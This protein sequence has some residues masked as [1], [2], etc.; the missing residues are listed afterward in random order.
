[1]WA[2]A[3]H[4]AAGPGQS[5]RGVGVSGPGTQCPR[6][7]QAATAC[8]G[9]ELRLPDLA[10]SASCE[11][12]EPLPAPEEAAG[13]T[14]QAEQ[15]GGGQAHAQQP[16][17]RLPALASEPRSP[18]GGTTRRSFPIVLQVTSVLYPFQKTPSS[19]SGHHG[20]WTPP[21][22]QTRLGT[23]GVS[24]APLAAS[25]AHG[26]AGGCVGWTE[27]HKEGQVD[28]GMDGW[29]QGWTG[30][31]I[32]RRVGVWTARQLLG[33]RDGWASMW[34]VG[35]GERGV[36]SP[37]VLTRRRLGRRRDSGQTLAGRV[38]VPPTRG[39]NSPAVRQAPVRWRTVTGHR[40][41]GL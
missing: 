31:Y 2:S 30:G 17:D 14:D 12:R 5:R 35:G 36:V 13:W 4:A 19:S 11:H 6:R 10:L 34:T 33:R 8:T 15:R 29:T 18:L 26:S 20:A 23:E 7:V 21:S 3:L 22:E 9:P 28:P 27:G 39:H 1:M 16:D 25:A 41:R 32:D 24:A 40:V 38:P 37:P